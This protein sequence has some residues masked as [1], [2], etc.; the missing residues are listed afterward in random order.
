MTEPTQNNEASQEEIK[1]P[2]IES[3]EPVPT[4]S[5]PSEETNEVQAE[6]KDDTVQVKTRTITTTIRDTW[7]RFIFLGV[8]CLVLIG[9][10]YCYDNPAPVEK[11]MKAVSWTSLFDSQLSI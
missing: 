3:S 5:L 8:C 4:T 2:L 11:K 6:F 7:W 9:S 10:Y 1:S